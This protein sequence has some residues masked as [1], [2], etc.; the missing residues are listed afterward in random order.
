M[1]R[2]D[3]SDAQRDAIIALYMQRQRTV[4]EAN[5]I[6]RQA[7]EAVKKIESAI[8]E[9]TRLVALAHGSTDKYEVTQDDTGRIALQRVAS[10]NGTES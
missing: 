10:A 5:A 3:L 4:E 2:I 6:L 8:G 7:E 9:L 1:E